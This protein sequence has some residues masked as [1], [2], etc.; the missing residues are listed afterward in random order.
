MR[1]KIIYSIGILILVVWGWSMYTASVS[2]NNEKSSIQLMTEDTL[3]G[4][5]SGGFYIKDLVTNAPVPYANITI[6]LIDDE[7]ISGNSVRIVFSEIANKNGWISF[8]NL[9]PN[10][11]LYKSSERIK[12]NYYVVIADN[13]SNTPK[14]L[15]GCIMVLSEP[16]HYDSWSIKIEENNKLDNLKT[17]NY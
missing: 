2:F 11:P 3:F 8:S 7:D 1:K 13:E 15:G 9:E 4:K 6:K 10:I 5:V 12:S 14:K 17:C 16:G